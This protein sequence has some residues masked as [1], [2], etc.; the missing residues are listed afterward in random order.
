[1]RE[2]MGGHHQ[3]S[4][5][6]GWRFRGGNKA[7][8]VNHYDDFDRPLENG[9][10]GSGISSISGIS[11]ESILQEP[12]SE[13]NMNEKQKDKQKKSVMQYSRRGRQSQYNN[14]NNNVN[15]NNNK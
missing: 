12:Q 8:H 4:H 1:M 7:K 5:E 10:I 2:G 11:Y 15:L 13:K 6:R 3:D 9:G 14:N